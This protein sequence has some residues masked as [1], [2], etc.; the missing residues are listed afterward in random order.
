MAVSLS[1]LIPRVRDLID[2][3]PDQTWATTGSAASAVSVVAVTNGADW[4]VGAVGEFQDD[5]E[6]FKVQS[7]NA[8]NLTCFRGWNGTTAATHVSGTIVRDPKVSYRQI[9]N[10]LTAALQAAWPYCYIVTTTQV[11]PLSDGTVWYAL[12]SADM[13]FLSARQVRGTA[14]ALHSGEYVQRSRHPGLNKRIVF[15]RDLPTSVVASGVGVRFPSGFYDMTTNVIV[16]TKRVLTGTSDIEDSNQLPVAEAII[17]GALPRLLTDVQFR[18]LLQ[19][20]NL[21]QAVQISTLG[22]IQGAAYY[23]Q[24]FRRQLESLRLAHEE[25]YRSESQLN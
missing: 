17:T 2:W 13:E 21:Q 15:S 14:P 18:R 25:L 20:V 4:D 1:A 16:R 6:Q 9:N 24:Q 10:A 19:G 23:E 8:N 5:G 11:T 3:G 22:P 7:I 12:N